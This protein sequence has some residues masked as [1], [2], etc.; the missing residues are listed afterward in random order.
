M[1]RLSRPA[2]LACAALTAAAALAA[3]QEPSGTP[4]STDARPAL[5]LRE[6]ASAAHALA[7]AEGYEKAGAWAEAAVEYQKVLD[8]EADPADPLVGVDES[9]QVAPEGASRYE[10][11]RG[12]ALRR[13]AAWPEEARRLLTERTAGPARSLW[14]Q[15]G[16]DAAA[17]RRLA[18]R[19]PFSPVGDQA[20]DR[21]AEVLLE[22]GDPLG[23]L[24]AWS[25]LRRLRPD[26]P[27]AALAQRKLEAVREYLGVEKTGDP[28]V[29]PSARP[30]L[31]R[32]SAVVD[33]QA[34]ALR[35]D[36]ALR[37]L[38]MPRPYL[39]VADGAEVFLAGA[40]GISVL[41]RASGRPLWSSGDPVASSRRPTDGPLAAC[42]AGALCLATLDGRLAAFERRGGLKVWETPA[43]AQ[44]VTPPSVRDGVAY[45]GV[46]VPV[47][48][49]VSYEAWALLA[50]NGRALWKRPLASSFDTGLASDGLRG[51][52]ALLPSAL[53]VETEMGCLASLDAASGEILWLMRYDVL[54]EGE[55][56]RAQR[57]GRRW[58]PGP[59]LS[60]EGCL[61]AAP[62]DCG[63]LLCVSASDGALRWREPRRE[64]DA[65]LAVHGGRVLLS[66]AASAR[67]LALE[68]RKP[69]WETPVDIEG[70]GCLGSEGLVLPGR[71]G[72]VILDPATGRVLHRDLWTDE[73]LRGSNLLARSGLVLACS[74]ARLVAFEPEP[75]SRRRL[76]ASGD[77]L[78]LGRLALGQGDPQ[79]ALAAFSRASGAA[80]TEGRAE[81][82]A[83]Q[84]RLREDAGDWP[85]AGEAFGRAAA[86]APDALRRMA[87]AFREGEDFR[88]ASR[89]A[90]AVAAFQRMIEDPS[91]GTLSWAHGVLRADW[92]GRLA[93]EEVL[94]ESG[95]GAYEAVEQRAQERLSQGGLREVVESF[96]NSLACAR[97]ARPPSASL[98]PRL[99]W[100][101]RRGE[102]FLTPP[103]G[104]PLLCEIEDGGLQALDPASGALRWE[105]PGTRGTSSPLWISDLVVLSE[106]ERLLALDPSDGKPR[107][108]V[109]AKGR[110]LHV[111][112]LPPSSGGGLVV[113]TLSQALFLD[114]E[115][116]ERLRLEM[117]APLA[118][119][120]L[121]AGKLLLAVT[122]SSGIAPARARWIDL[123]AGKEIA[124]LELGTESVGAV[125]TPEGSG[126][127]LILLG[128]RRLLALSLD[129][130][131]G[132]APRWEQAS[133]TP[134]WQDLVTAK[135]QAILIPASEEEKPRLL[136]LAPE[137]G[138]KLW[139]SELLE[140]ELTSPRILGG[141]LVACLSSPGRTGMASWALDSGTL[142]WRS[143]IWPQAL[144][145][146]QVLPLP[147][148][149]LVWA[150]SRDEAA[151]LDPASGRTLRAYDGLHD[152]ASVV[153]PLG[154]GF[155]W[156]GSLAASAWIPCEDLD[157]LRPLWRA[158]A[159]RPSP[160]HPRE[161]LALADACFRSGAYGEALQALGAA[162]LAGD[163]SVPASEIRARLEPWR[164][165]EALL[166][167]EVMK[168]QHFRSPPQI[169]GDLRD[170]WAEHLRRELRIPVDLHVF[171]KGRDPKAVW[172][173]SE[174]L[175][176][177][178][179]LAWD[180]EFFYF[181]A[182][183]DDQKEVV[184]D[185]RHPGKG[186][187]LF[188]SIDAQ[189]NGR[190]PF[191]GGIA[192]Q[193]PRP[194]PPDPA[195][196]PPGD[197]SARRRPDDSGTVYEA[198]I[199]W[200]S[201]RGGPPVE[202]GELRI[203]LLIGDDDGDGMHKGL[204][205]APG[206]PTHRF[207]EEEGEGRTRMTP[208]LFLKVRLSD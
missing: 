69:L 34:D 92:V 179:Y 81:A 91:G 55:R 169:D 67:A 122:S 96:P 125:Q 113:E 146:A 27:L 42:P 105:R 155:L 50:R 64:S 21:L 198:A 73:T 103:P 167:G 40:G 154:E 36:H 104:L 206:F 4:S 93:I 2:V 200:S 161:A 131:A 119:P 186:D 123:A 31:P 62:R 18:G 149:L 137:S 39:P 78:G 100:R 139:E 7:L 143:D 195:T 89:P 87:W 196:L 101:M 14:L 177:R 57:T 142:R 132:T 30:G 48:P 145:G 208:A 83:L 181:A 174:D 20:L 99:T 178:L 44:V 24:A 71:E 115:G 35:R 207:D 79:R 12:R 61:L 175:S 151:L 118:A 171:A 168:A 170:G 109:Q 120:P 164:E 3:L 63:A 173:G 111:W 60:A 126:S 148:G 5:F 144:T 134:C 65:L 204:L 127:A 114:A 157:V 202:E 72:P 86:S 135:G 94:E 15:A 10:S 121:P 68:D 185:E 140:G 98:P 17:L 90:Q 28:S 51:G 106:G 29:L 172:S 141:A 176:A 59:P 70:L 43:S 192:I 97:E 130:A 180:E 128:S 26:S 56:R 160:E 16:A 85:G 150:P 190:N 189:G 6:D 74:P 165:T 11:A 110:I 46:L 199:P 147:S 184:F 107:W 205:L 183:V 80:A 58:G 138:R 75:E 194:K 76:E 153:Q 152:P 117:G 41:D 84:G 54:S 66:G 38:P 32:W 203:N 33:P 197:Y 19:Y 129:P 95:R 159:T 49:S 163:P 133:P 82:E 187:L 53:A 47:G 8:L 1:L 108:N 13:L 25:A 45:V 124:S 182:D 116:R 201:L 156:V 193:N 102:A 188:F 191:Q 37:G 166:A 9:G 136:A 22:S 88:K 162:A 23:A 52:L 77:A 158:R 112:P